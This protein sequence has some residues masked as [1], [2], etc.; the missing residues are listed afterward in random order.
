MPTKPR[1]GSGGGRLV[2]RARC[3]SACDLARAPKVRSHAT[4]LLCPS[5]F[6]IKWSRDAGRVPLKMDERP[7][8][9]KVRETCSLRSTSSLRAVNHRAAKTYPNDA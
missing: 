1:V 3:V 2:P 9:W 5:S 4:H 6:Y 7:V 8:P